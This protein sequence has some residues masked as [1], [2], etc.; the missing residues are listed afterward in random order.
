MSSKQ[1]ALDA[2][3]LVLK[4]EQNPKQNTN[5]IKYKIKG[6]TF[7]KW[8]PGNKSY[9]DILCLNIGHKKMTKILISMY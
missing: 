7:I 5:I 1:F 3:G 6:K 8:G 9:T 4:S 2:S